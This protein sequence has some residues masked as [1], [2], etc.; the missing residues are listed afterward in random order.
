MGF[1]GQ[2]RF[3]GKHQKIF[4]LQALYLF[5]RKKNNKNHKYP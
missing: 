2:E 4:F 1:D 3:E 5:I